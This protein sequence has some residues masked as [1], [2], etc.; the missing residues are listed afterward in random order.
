MS[1]DRFA[2]RSGNGSEITRLEAATGRVEELTT[3]QLKAMAL[4]MTGCAMADVAERIGVSRGTIHN[5]THRNER[6]IAALESWRR[7]MR[8]NARTRLIAMSNLGLRAIS[9]ALEGG[10]ARV[11]LRMFT[12]LG[13][14]GPK[15]AEED[16]QDEGKTILVRLRDEPDSDGGG[17][18]RGVVAREM[19]GDAEGGEDGAE[20]AP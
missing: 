2:G 5:W 11:A 9:Q 13:V 7:D 1:D 16:K 18:R 8:R 4:L 17:A 19:P 14:L 10:D 3:Q 6:F 15:V 12:G 20:R